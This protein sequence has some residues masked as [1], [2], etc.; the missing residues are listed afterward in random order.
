MNKLLLNPHITIFGIDIYYYALIIVSG[1]I[2]A[3][4]LTGILLK[5]RG[6]PSDSAYIYAIAVIPIAVLSARLYFFI[7]PYKGETSDWSRFWNFRDGGLGIYG[8]II[9]GAIALLITA[10]IL[11]H[12]LLVAADCAIPGVALAQAIGRW[13]NFVNQEAYG[14]LITN[15]DWQWFPAAVYIDKEGGWFNATFFYESIWNLIGVTFML[16]LFFKAYRKGL[17][18][19]TYCIWYGIGRFWIEGLRSDSL[20][21]GNTNIKVSQ[22][23]S[24]ILIITGVVLYCF[25]YREEIKKLYCKLFNKPYTPP[26]VAVEQ[27][28]EVVA[29]AAIENTKTDQIIRKGERKSKEKNSEDVNKE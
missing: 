14:N 27:G 13:G 3:I 9:V 12:K 16:L 10:Y 24:V 23:V 21:L 5:K 11:K 26:I 18:L 8:G 20:M 19:G 15:K 25:V 1:M 7:F 17:I 22:F 29:D 28:G 6:Y 2:L 4:I